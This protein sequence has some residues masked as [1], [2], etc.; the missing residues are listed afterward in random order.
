[1]LRILICDFSGRQQIH[2]TLFSLVLRFYML[3]DFTVVALSKY[4]S[5]FYLN[6]VQ[7]NQQQM[8]M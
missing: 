5:F 3:K 6:S 4:L 1:M 2:N 8:L 7:V